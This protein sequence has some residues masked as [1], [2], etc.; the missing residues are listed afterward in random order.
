MSLPSTEQLKRALE[1]RA[2]IESLEQELDNLIGGTRNGA[3]YSGPRR[4]MSGSVRTRVARGQPGRRKMPAAAKAK[5]A[6]IAR[7]RWAKAKAAGKSR[8]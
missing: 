3:G 6:A 8:L 5:L 4:R 7:A 2:K 1:I